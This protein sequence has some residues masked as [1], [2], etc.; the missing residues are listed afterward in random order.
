MAAA[1]PGSPCSRSRPA[2]QCQG[3]WPQTNAEDHL[4]HRPRPGISAAG[5]PSSGGPTK[6]GPRKRRRSFPW[7]FRHTRPCTTRPHQLDGPPDVT[8]E[9]CTLRYGMVVG[10]LLIRKGAGSSPA[11][12]AQAPGHRLTEP[13]WLVMRSLPGLW[14]SER[15]DRRVGGDPT[16]QGPSGPPGPGQQVAALVE[17]LTEQEL[18]V[19]RLLAARRS[20]AGIAAELV[21]EQSTSRR[22][23]SMCTASWASTAVPRRWPAPARCGCSTDPGRRFHLC[24]PPSGGRAPPATPPS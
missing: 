19:L 7:S 16:A 13:A 18:E 4:A 9:D 15:H 24:S 3:G 6:I 5:C 8:S 11:R 12:G 2:D 23:S 17:S 20:N 1:A 14:L 21:V 10:R 22:T